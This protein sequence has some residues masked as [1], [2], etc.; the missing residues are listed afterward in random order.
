MFSGIAGTALLTVLQPILTALFN[1]VGRSFDDWLASRRA[2][3]ALKDLGAAQV[4]GAI[5][6]EA[7]NDERKVAQVAINQPDVAAALDEWSAGKEF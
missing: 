7:A 5:N 2:E 6:K 3:Q 1:A 4:T